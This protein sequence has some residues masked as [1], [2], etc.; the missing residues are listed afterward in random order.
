MRAQQSGSVCNQETQPGRA[1]HWFRNSPSSRNLSRDS[2]SCSRGPLCCH[3]SISGSRK[4][5]F[6][7]PPPALMAE[8]R[9]RRAWEQ[10]IPSIVVELSDEESW[11]YSRPS[12][13]WMVQFSRSPSLGGVS[14]PEG[15]SAETSQ[16][17]GSSLDVMCLA[18][19]STTRHSDL[20]FKKGSRKLFLKEEQKS[21]ALWGL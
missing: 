11:Q 7:P 4:L 5:S 13:E 21:P 10:S 8:S 18:P 9:F 1:E 14:F 6:R 19:I 2:K 3:C 12:R 15:I 16:R 17:R 20:C